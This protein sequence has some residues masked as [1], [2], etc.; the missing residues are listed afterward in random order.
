MDISNYIKISELSTAS[1]LSADDS[2]IVAQQGESRQLSYADLSTNFNDAI[3]IQVQIELSDVS[4]QIQ[5]ISA[6]LDGHLSDYE[7]L[8]S[9]VLAL[10]N[11]GTKT[12]KR[13]D[14]LSTSVQELSSIILTESSICNYV[15]ISAVD[16]EH[17][18]TLSNHVPS[19][20]LLSTMYESLE[21]RLISIDQDLVNTYIKYID[22][23]GKIALCS[24]EDVK[25]EVRKETL[26]RYING[27]GLGLSDNVQ[28]PGLSTF[29]VDYDVVISNVVSTLLST[30]ID[31]PSIPIMQYITRSDYEALSTYDENVYYMIDDY[32]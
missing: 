32:Q 15:N 22:V 21:E 8:V 2:F 5:E 16:V 9:S 19:S 26:A 13:I 28:V 27:T 12:N 20:P 30:T 29:Y 1:R 11:C 3:K 17:L 6:K 24:I 25:D 10:R 4:G 7:L 23:E 18:T 31:S 14:E